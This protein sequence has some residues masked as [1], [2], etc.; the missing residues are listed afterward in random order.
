M[1]FVNLSFFFSSLGARIIEGDA[2]LEHLVV[3]K[4][5]I[6]DIAIMTQR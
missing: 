5:L 1:I 4:Y 3:M 2:K 6:V